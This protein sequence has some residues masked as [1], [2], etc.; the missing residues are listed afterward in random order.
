MHVLKG[1]IILMLGI[2]M[3]SSQSEGLPGFLGGIENVA[4]TASNFRK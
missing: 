3:I 1:I 2:H 4:N